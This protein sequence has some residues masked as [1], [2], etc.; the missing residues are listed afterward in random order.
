M[1][2]IFSAFERCIERSNSNAKIPFSILCALD[3]AQKRLNSNLSILLHNIRTLIFGDRTLSVILPKFFLAFECWFFHAIIVRTLG[4]IP[5]NFD[6]L[7]SFSSLFFFL[8]SILKILESN[9]FDAR[10]IGIS[11][12]L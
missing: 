3:A 8:R 5:G 11:K 9:F 2:K 6:F 10:Y 7:F 12:T 1:Q 4:V